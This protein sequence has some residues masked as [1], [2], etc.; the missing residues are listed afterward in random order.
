M[1]V[2]RWLFSVRRRHRFGVRRYEKGG[3]GVRIVTLVLMLVI[4]GAA[5]GLEAWGLS[6]FGE[7]ILIGIL[8]LILAALFV[9]AGSEFCLVYAIT[10]IRMYVR[11]KAEKAARRADAQQTPDGEERQAPQ[12]G[13]APR[14]YSGFD[15]FLF[16]LG[17][18]LAVG[19]IAA[20]ILIGVTW[21]S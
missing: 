19:N 21:F 9:I 14:A 5:L 12:D 13:A 18:L 6:M 1:N 11:G 4:C 2:L 20:A 15:L 17:L 10:A 7:N 16:F 3:M 8:L